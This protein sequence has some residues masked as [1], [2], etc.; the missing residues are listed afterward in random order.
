M[1]EKIMQTKQTQ[2]EN[3]QINRRDPSTNSQ[4]N[5]QGKMPINYQKY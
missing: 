1:N 2:V 4:K 3:K 5:V